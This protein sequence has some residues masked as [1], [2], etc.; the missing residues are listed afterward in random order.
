LKSWQQLNVVH[1]QL[2]WIVPTSFL[3]AGAEVYVVANVAHNGWGWIILPIGLGSGLGSLCS[4]ML[5]KRTR[6]G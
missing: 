5:H 4:T 2:W 3:M 1:Y 6:R